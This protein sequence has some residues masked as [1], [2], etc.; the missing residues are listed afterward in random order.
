MVFFDLVA[1]FFRR[2]ARSEGAAGGGGGGGADKKWKGNF[3]FCFAATELHKGH[4]NYHN[5]ALCSVPCGDRGTL[6]H[7]ELFISSLHQPEP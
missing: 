7:N 3:W 1:G 6:T 4:Q 2:N 5:V